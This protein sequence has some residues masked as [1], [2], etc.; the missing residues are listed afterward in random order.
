MVSDSG[1]NEILIG[2]IEQNVDMNADR[3]YDLIGD[4]HGCAHT[5]ISLLEQLGYRKHQ[6]C[7]QHPSR[8]AVFV[9]DF[10]DRGG[11][12]RETLNLVY[13]M[14]Q[15]GAAEVVLGNHEYNAIAWS[16]SIETQE[17]PRFLREH[18]P[19]HYEAIKETLI[20]FEGHL[21]DW[22]EFVSWFRRMP[23]YLQAE[24]FRVIHACWDQ[25]LVAGLQEQQINDFSDH[26]F[27]VES[28]ERGTF[29]C[30]VADRL[31]RGT[32]MPLPNEH[33]MQSKD[34]FLRRAYRTK[35]WSP[36]ASTHGELVFQPDPLP[37]EIA[38]LDLTEDEKLR[39][40]H[41]GLEQPLLFVGHYWQTGTPQPV[42]KNI[43]CLD[44]SAV[45]QGK[46]AAYRLDNEPQLLREK[47]VWVDM[48]PRD[49][50]S[51]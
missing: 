29:S 37:H 27:L 26:D 19:R 4:I 45:K 12:I 9:G 39:L 17:R 49:L 13:D 33:I 40:V 10:V 28:T 32:W 47:F 35:F 21:A 15:V 18:N 46:L 11:F 44:Y 30:Q 50:T 25:P 3:G 51:R 20:Q 31:L 1:G 36:S 23:I 38:S 43:A 48:D 14:V 7:Y 2:N 22:R 5:L 24:H 6:G 34:G 16:T 8:K 41:Y 42:T